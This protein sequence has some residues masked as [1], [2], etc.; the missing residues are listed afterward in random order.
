MKIISNKTINCTLSK[1]RLVT[2]EVTLKKEKRQ[3]TEWGKIVAFSLS[4]K[5]VISKIYETYDTQ[6]FKKNPT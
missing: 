6:Q 1:M 5:S 3:Y 2:S 4:D